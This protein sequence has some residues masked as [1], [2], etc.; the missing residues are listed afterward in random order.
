[1]SEGMTLLRLHPL[2]QE[3]VGMLDRAGV[4]L[5]AGLDLLWKFHVVAG[6]P[7]HAER[8][9]SEP[10]GVGTAP[11]EPAPGVC[12]GP[13]M[14]SVKGGLRSLDDAALASHGLTRRPGKAKAKAKKGPAV[15]RNPAWRTCDKCGLTKGMRGFEA[16]AATCRKCTAPESI[17][18]PPA[19]SKKAKPEPVK[20]QRGTAS[21]GPLKRCLYCDE[22]KP[23]KEFGKGEACRACEAL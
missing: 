18:T 1:M 5:Q 23:L 9:E 4:G 8:V 16:G 12:V 13:L 2:E 15:R 3:L 19:T 17:E 14:E 7:D 22:K 10:E 11:S 6:L 20:A 21:A